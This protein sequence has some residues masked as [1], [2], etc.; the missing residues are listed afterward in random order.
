M[1]DHFIGN[2]M[3]YSDAMDLGCSNMF[4][5]FQAKQFHGD[6]FFGSLFD[7]FW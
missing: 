7:M 4:H 6:M 3:E 1:T 2:M 5:D